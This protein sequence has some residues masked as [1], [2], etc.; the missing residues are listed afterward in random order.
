MVDELDPAE[1]EDLISNIKSKF[2]NSNTAW[3][4]EAAFYL[5][6]NM[7]S[8]VKDVLSVFNSALDYPCSLLK[9]NFHK[10]LTDLFQLFTT[11]ELYQVQLSIIESVIP[12]IYLTGLS[13]P[14]GY[15]LFLQS[16]S[17][18]LGQNSSE[19]IERLASVEVRNKYKEKPNV[20]LTQVWCLQSAGV[21]SLKEGLTV[22]K[23][24]YLPVL[25]HKYFYQFG[26]KYLSNVLRCV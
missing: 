7:P 12:N 22:W 25:D 10:K 24:L 14:V 1:F 11:E 8:N 6:N 3:L 19:S 18:Y 5:N 20:Y 15:L 4:S 23:R 9:E 21:L 13:G 2:P 26:L 16:L 17:L